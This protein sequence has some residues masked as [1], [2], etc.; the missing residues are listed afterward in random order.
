MLSRVEVGLKTGFC[1]PLGES[2][3]KRVSSDLG[4][5]AKSV[6]TIRVF[7][8]EGNFSQKD[9]A[10]LA[11]KVF[12]DP[13]IQE[14]SVNKPLARK[15]GFDWLVEVS[16]RPG[17]TD[18]VGRTAREAVGYALE[19]ALAEDENVFTGMQ[20]LLKGG[21]DEKDVKKIASG[22]LANGL[23]ERF[24]IFSAKDF[25]FEKGVSAQSAR[26]IDRHTPKVEEIDLNVSDTELE[27]MS[28]GRLL[29][30]SLHEMKSVQ[31]YFLDAGVRE[32]RK[33]HGLSRNPSDVE[34][35][36]IAQTWS[37]HCKHKI[38]NAQI[39]YAEKNGKNAKTRKIDSLFK[40]YI[41]AA[42]ETV[43]KERNWLVSV[44]HDNAGVISFNKSHDIAFKVETHNSPSALDP[45][46]GALT[47]IVGVNRDTLGTGI[48]FKPIFNTDVFCFASPFYAGTLPDK[49]LHP[50]RIFE[51]VRRGVE[52]GGNKSGIPTVNGCIVFDD[53]FRGKPLVYCG[54]AG[55]APKKIGKRNSVE[56]NAE[57]GFLALM[58]GGRIGKDGIHGATFSSEELHE[59]SP[60]TAVQLGDPITQKKMLDCILEARDLGLI[61]SITDNGAGGLSSSIGEMARATNGCEIWLDRAPL[62]YAGLQPWEILVS[63]SQERMTV[64]IIPENLEKFN[65]LC[66]KHAVESTAV[67]KFTDSG[68]FH[69]KFKD[70]TVA[71]LEM[72]FFHDGVPQMKLEAEWE[73]R[74]A[75][76]NVFAE[77]SDL[78]AELN[79][80]LARLNVCSKEFVVRQYDHEVQGSSIVK[81][82][83]GAENDGPSDAGVVKPL[84]DSFEGIVVSNGLCPRL[85]DADAYWM[86]ANA[87]DEAV[88][89]AVATGANP[90]HIA[91][92]DNF[93]WPDPV[94][95]SQKNPDGKFKLGQLV[96]ANKALYDLAVAYGTPFISGK[97][98][99][100]NDYRIGGK[101][102]SIPPTV[103]VSAIAKIDDVRKAVTIDAKRAGDLV[104]VLGETK[105]EL[106]CSEYFDSKGFFGGEVPKVDAK[107]AR[108][109][110]SAL[111]KAIEKGLLASCHDISDGGLAVCLS[112]TAFAGGLGI[113]ADL[114]KL[115]F[116]GERRDDFALFSESP[117]RFVVTV[118]P[119][120]KS[121]FEK[122][123]SGNGI[124]FVG[125]V[126]REK[127]LLIT[128]FE[129]KAVIDEKIDVLKA[130]WQKTLKW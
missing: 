84:F 20:Y 50:K 98:S 45:Y 18:N 54:T 53:R 63:E 114:R 28:R 37:E 1:D 70:K 107:K 5:N 4:L 119:E 22:L 10:F 87:L 48:G 15:G 125:L 129:G 94:F 115:E 80:L 124:S 75:E 85:S 55:I 2:V 108:K 74:T 127:R 6:K 52:H 57:P 71:L 23:I 116:A 78:G 122:A 117:S 9:L 19:R 120:N 83:E 96:R 62:K 97:D 24:E 46:G 90:E 68:F 91:V 31:A 66:K 3:K 111:A 27:K 34:L 67:G 89:N 101:K 56:K 82:L 73:P 95:D 61:E 81:P 99:M 13:V 11:E 72:H 26:V 17:V 79:A 29:A 32:K 93:C 105:A 8:L 102:I 128:G 33:T 35:E 104:Y 42:T 69:A 109:L 36:A 12:I 43:S 92:L 40:S 110:Y 30:L 118:A 25:D 14:F 38:F 123:L 126:L 103:L 64:A 41:R 113:E 16:F 60:V 88:R 112:E 44:F 51:G 65:A 77:P 47:G 39:S 21:L 58:V 59:G 86:A 121:E 76:E 130:S 106:A 100:K 7:T 49:M